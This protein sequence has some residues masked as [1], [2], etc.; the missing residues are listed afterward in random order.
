MLSRGIQVGIVLGLCASAAS[1]QLWDTGPWD[2]VDGRASDTTDDH[3]R[4]WTRAADDVILAEGT[5]D[6]YAIA[7]ISGR[8]LAVNY[9]DAIAEIYEDAGGMPADEPTWVLAE[10]GREVLDT[11]VFGLYDLVNFTFDGAG[12]E[13]APGTYWVSISCN[14]IGSGSNAGYAFFGTAGNGELLGSEG[15][16]RVEGFDWEPSLT[17]MGFSTDFSFTVI[18]EQTNPCPPDWNGDTVLNSSDFIAFLNDFTGGN[19]DYNGD[20]ITNSSDFIAFLNDFT[21]GC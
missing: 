3:V 11:G 19:A 15:Y 7:E 14:V 6:P 18:G 1:A 13:L 2:G 8:M 5:G 21:A 12:L 9:V 4:P 17:A 16:W 20:T 10:T